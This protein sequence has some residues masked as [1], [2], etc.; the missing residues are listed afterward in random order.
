MTELLC[1]C[2]RK[3]LMIMLLST[4]FLNRLGTAWFEW[5]SKEMMFSV[6]RYRL[7]NMLG[8]NGVQ[9]DAAQPQNWLLT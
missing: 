6:I 4:R 2:V 5:V 3:Y 9:G 7:Q 8:V 1:Q